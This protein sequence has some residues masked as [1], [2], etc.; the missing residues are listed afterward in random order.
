ND[1]N[2]QSQ[3]ATKPNKI[4]RGPAALPTL[5]TGP[6][7]NVRLPS[8]PATHEAPSPKTETKHTTDAFAATTLSDGLASIS[9]VPSC[10]TLT[11]DGKL[12]VLSADGNEPSLTGIQQALD[13]LGT[14]YM[15]WIATA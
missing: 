8:A 2:A 9:S 13:Y 1:Q 10:T 12:L 7:P 11:L 6:L 14:P 3:S 15:L 5:P 4:R